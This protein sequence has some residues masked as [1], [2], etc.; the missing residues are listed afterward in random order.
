MYAYKGIWRTIKGYKKT[1][2]CEREN[3]NDTEREQGQVEVGKVGERKEKQN[4]RQ[5]NNKA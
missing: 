2:K 1:N 5:A 3:E 4:K